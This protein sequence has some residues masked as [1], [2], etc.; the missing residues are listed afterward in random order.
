MTISNRL[1]CRKAIL[2][3]L[4][5]FTYERLVAGETGIE[6]EATADSDEKASGITAC[7]HLLNPA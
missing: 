6:T 1:I 3:L 5:M 2:F 7:T 4:L